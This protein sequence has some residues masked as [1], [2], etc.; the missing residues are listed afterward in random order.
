MVF[1]QTPGLSIST[2]AVTHPPNYLGAV[3][4]SAAA[5]QFPRPV[6]GVFSFLAGP[7]GLASLLSFHLRTLLLVYVL[8]PKFDHLLGHLHIKGFD[9]GPRGVPAGF[10]MG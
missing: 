4:V 9:Q 7:V 3:R 6:G 1:Q 5:A 8:D 2:T 10:H